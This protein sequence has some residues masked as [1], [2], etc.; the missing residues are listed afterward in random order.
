MQ[1]Q[2]PESG[3]L[4]GEDRLPHYDESYYEYDHEWG[5]DS[6]PLLPVPGFGFLPAAL[7]QELDQMTRKILNED[8]ANMSDVDMSNFSLS[9]LDHFKCTI[10][11]ETWQYFFPQFADKTEEGLCGPLWDGASCIPPTLAGRT[12]VWPGPA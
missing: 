3:H 11:N 12:A 7:H 9:T 10:L 2:E 4:G 6:E 5:W 1:Q 8:V